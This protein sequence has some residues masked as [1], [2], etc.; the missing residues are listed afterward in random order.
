MNFYGDQAVEEQAAKIRAIVDTK[1]EDRKPEE[2]A[3]VLAQVQT[4]SRLLLLDI[5]VKARKPRRR[6]EEDAAVPE[7]D[8]AARRQTRGRRAECAEVNCG[9]C[10]AADC[11]QRETAV[12]AEEARRQVRRAG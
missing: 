4:A 1:A 2:V 7:G 8:A 5:G 12:V 9:E 11:G 3:N 6:R 10:A